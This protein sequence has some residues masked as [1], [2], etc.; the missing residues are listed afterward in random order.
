M[1]TRSPWPVSDHAEQRAITL[2]RRRVYFMPVPKSGC[3]SVLWWMASVAGLSR[4]HFELSTR[5]QVSPA[6]TVHDLELWRPAN[7]WRD[8]TLEQ[9]SEFASDPSWLRFTV[10]RDPASRLW[11][12]WQSKLLMREPAFV[13]RFRKEPWFPRVPTEP[14]HV[15][16]DFR[17]FVR[18]LAGEPA[19]A[20]LDPHWIPQSVLLAA[21]PPLTHVG[22]TERFAETID[23]LR[24]HT[25]AH[26]PEQVPRENSGLLPYHPGLYDDE[27]RESLVRLYADDFADFGYPH[28]QSSADGW[29][30]DWRVVVRPVLPAIGELID[31]HERMRKLFWMIRRSEAQTSSASGAG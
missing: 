17:A 31:R 6:L 19:N 18:A 14:D 8:L 20:P 29:Y 16:E 13:R 4:E 27:A 24:A 28:P 1:S 21:A 11:S 30:D 23:V 26:G 12:A 2:P 5:P 9:R 10:V 22:R 3:T 25:G 15:I 7:R